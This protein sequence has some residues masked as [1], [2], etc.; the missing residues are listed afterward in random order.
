MR[1]RKLS[2][3]GLVIILIGVLLLYVIG[4][5]I[6]KIFNPTNVTVSL[7]SEYNVV[8][9]ENNQIDPLDYIQSDNK[10]KVIVEGEVKE[11]PGIYTISYSA[12][13][14]DA[15]DKVIKITFIHGLTPE[16]TITPFT[17]DGTVISNK[18]IPLPQD[19]DPGVSEEAMAAIGE[20]EKAMLAEDLAFVLLSG[21]RTYSY[22]EGLFNKY[23]E[24][25]GEE[26]ANKYSARAGYSEHQTGLA[27]DFNWINDEFSRTKEYLWLVDNAHNYGFILRYPEGKEEITGYQYEPWHWRY[28]GKELATNIYESGKTLEE[29]FNIV[30]ES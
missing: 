14:K 29:Y 18:N 25:N 2:K 12:S 17:I 1:K 24:E 21:Y 15:E 3:R 26:E 30:V 4:V 19:Y 13:Q 9:T 23:V 11:T 6:Y 27:F 16:N 7:E 5:G 10:S 20:L 8:I 22:Q 28:V